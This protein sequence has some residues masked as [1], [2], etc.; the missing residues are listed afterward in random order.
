MYCGSFSGEFSL[1]ETLRSCLQ[2]TFLACVCYYRPQCSYG[3]VMFL[4]ASLILFTGG[5]G[6]RPPSEQ[7]HPLGRRLLQRTVRILLECMLVIFIIIRITTVMNI[8][9]TMLYN[10]GG[11]NGHGLKALRVNRPLHY[12]QND[13]NDIQTVSSELNLKGNGNGACACQCL[14]GVVLSLCPE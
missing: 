1:V 6:D 11:N 13:I 10:N 9:T 5:G 8:V 12:I 7:T 2:V 3:K 4:Q 14:C